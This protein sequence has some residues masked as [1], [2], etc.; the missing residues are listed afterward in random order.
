MA[1]K[2]LSG[3]GRPSGTEQ[4]GDQM[5]R[6]RLCQLAARCLSVDRATNGSTKE[7]RTPK[8]G[9]ARAALNLREV[10]RASLEWEGGRLSRMP[11]RSSKGRV[12]MVGGCKLGDVVGE[13]GLGGLTWVRSDEEG[14]V[15]RAMSE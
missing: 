11:R 14:R 12:S 2:K 3:I 4:L 9:L 15:L 10:R 1:S 13:G 8:V 5:T 6:G 7:A